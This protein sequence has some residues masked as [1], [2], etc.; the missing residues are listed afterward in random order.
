MRFSVLAIVLATLFAL[1]PSFGQE[2]A[3]DSNTDL[4][5]GTI[6]VALGNERGL[7][8]L[9]DSMITSGGHQLAVPGQKLF[10]LDDRT[11]CAFAGFASAGSTE[12][13]ELNA[14][15]R[16]IILEYIRQSSKQERQTIAEK[17]RALASLFK[18][19]LS[20]IA[21]VR[22]AVGNPSPITSYS[23]QIIVAGFDMDG[24]PKIG[25]VTLG[26]TDDAGSLMS[27][28]REAEI[29]EVGKNIIW[30]L[31]GM[32]DVANK[33]LQ[34]PRSGPKDKI[35]VE[36][37]DAMDKDHGRSFTLE[38]MTT[39]AKRLAFYSAKAHPEVGGADQIAILQ[40]PD[41]I[42]VEQP[43]F[44][45]PPKLLFR[46]SLGVNSHFAYSSVV[47]AGNDP[48]VFIRCS[49]TGMSSRIDNSYFI[50]STFTK[51]TLLYDGGDINL[52][53]TNHVVDTVLALGPHTKVDDKRVRQL[54]KAFSWS[55]IVR[56]DA[57]GKVSDL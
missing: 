26:T 32:P 21:N 19:H 1:S 49:W 41:H 14:S 50:G 54:M 6:N 46:F 2:L 56:V 16:A 30:R 47:F 8:V 3:P 31:N 27:N 7:V 34:S 24:K 51:A 4:A 28:I 43:T 35:F 38:Q 20:A 18:L 57:T 29:L 52:G 13:P 45:E 53:T 22:D 44:P 55:R 33:I 25:R 37:A 39:L 48:K 11:V 9:T 15:T 12:A 17:L 23:F 5:H 40:D 42:V 36:F 10:K